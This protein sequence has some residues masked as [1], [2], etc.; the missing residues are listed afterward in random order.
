MN[1]DRRAIHAPTREIAAW[2]SALR[3][4]DLPERTRTVARCALLDTLGCGVYGYN[5]PW[6]GMLL[7]WARP[8]P[9]VFEKP[10]LARGASVAATVPV[11]GG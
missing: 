3:Y 10:P 2:V 5:T 4:D 11:N 6:A 1:F 9:A 8:D 7:A